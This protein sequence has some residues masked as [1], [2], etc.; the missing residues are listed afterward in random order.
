[1]L[2]GCSQLCVE[3]ASPGSHEKQ[4]AEGAGGQEKKLH[5]FVTVTSMSVDAEGVENRFQGEAE[6]ENEKI[7]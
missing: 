2:L 4:P 6:D 7:V 5:I 3:C 1:M